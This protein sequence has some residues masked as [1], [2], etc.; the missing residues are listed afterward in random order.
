MKKTV[1]MPRKKIQAWMQNTGHPYM[2]ITHAEK[3]ENL[4]AVQPNLYSTRVSPLHGASSGDID[5][6]TTRQQ[7]FILAMSSSS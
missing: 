4:H 6:T 5:S 7:Q 2:I 1:L 3:V